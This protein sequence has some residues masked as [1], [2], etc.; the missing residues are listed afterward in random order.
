MSLRLIMLATLALL[1]VVSGRGQPSGYVEVKDVQHLPGVSL[2]C[3]ATDG[4]YDQAHLLALQKKP[5]CQQV[6]GV[7]AAFSHETLF[8][9]SAESDCH[10]LVITKVFRADSEKRYHIILNNIYGGCRAGGWRDGFLVFEKLPGY[11]VD[12]AEVQVE[13]Y[14]R[15]AGDEFVFPKPKVNDGP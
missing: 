14:P 8:H 4:E 6:R 1:L 2:G 5:N 15:R 9:W 11:A 12:F 3:W 13:R 10:M 7:K